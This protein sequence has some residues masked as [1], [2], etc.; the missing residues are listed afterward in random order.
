[1]MKRVGLQDLVNV[2]LLL[3]VVIATVSLVR[4]RREH[5]SVPA[6]MASNT[7]QALDRA[8]WLSLVGG[9]ARFGPPGARDTIVVLSDFECP[10]CRGFAERVLPSLRRLPKSL[11]VYRHFPLN[12]HRFARPA[13]E[14][15]EC[16][17]EQ[18][19]FWEFSE[20]VF[21]RQDSLGL[22]SFEEIGRRAGVASVPLMTEC[23]R[24]RRHQR[25][26]EEDLALALKIGALGTPTV[27][28]NGRFS[29]DWSDSA[30]VVKLLQQ[31]P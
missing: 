2:V 3:C 19:K 6:A 24:T 16:A 26:V 29:A 31:V 10:A 12:Y 23:M 8:D 18:Q 5:A 4:G 20:G 25:L 1:M 28:H 27:I 14:A 9:G 22:L 7:G 13:A 11:V 30:K 21:A 15:A 17:A